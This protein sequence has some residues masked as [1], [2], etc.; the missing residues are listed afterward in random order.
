MDGPFWKL[1]LGMWYLAGADPSVSP[2][3]GLLDEHV[4]LALV[5]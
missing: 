3:R 4:V 5:L 1:V 2:L